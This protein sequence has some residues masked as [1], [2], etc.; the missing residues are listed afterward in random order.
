MHFSL[1]DRGTA[2]LR[3]YKEEGEEKKE[4]EIDSKQ[5]L[6]PHLKGMGIIW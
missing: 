3:E 2:L 1:K 4:E 6:N 5:V